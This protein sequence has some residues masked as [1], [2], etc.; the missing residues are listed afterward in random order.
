M[1][2]CCNQWAPKFLWLS[3]PTALEYYTTREFHPK[4]SSLFDNLQADD[5]YFLLPHCKTGKKRYLRYLGTVKRTCKDTISY[6]LPHKHVDF[7]RDPFRAFKILQPWRQS[8]TFNALP[9]TIDLLLL[10][11]NNN[12]Y[13]Y[14]FH[15]WSYFECYLPTVWKYGF[16]LEM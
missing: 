2:H 9:C 6:S 14:I 11:P 8:T 16:K 10:N 5:Q 3:W 7:W 13:T 12:V 4:L 15:D 1:T